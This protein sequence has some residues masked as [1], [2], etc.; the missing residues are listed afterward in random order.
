[1]FPKNFSNNSN[2]DD[3][4]I[5]LPVFPSRTNLKLH[6]LS[7]ELSTFHIFPNIIT[8]II[9]NLDLPKASS[10]DSITVVVLKNCEPELSFIQAKLFNKCLKESCFPDYWEVSLVPPVFKNFSKRSTA[11]NYHLVTLL[12][13]VSKVFEKLVDN[14]VVDHLEKCGLFS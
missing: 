4:G 13:V 2:L 8:K 6:N 14:R 11:K 12:S 3:S 5:F 9:K 10:P 1:M 7:V